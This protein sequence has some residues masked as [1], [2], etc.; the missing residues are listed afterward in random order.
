MTPTP[1]QLKRALELA[2]SMLSVH[3]L[4]DSRAVSDEFVALASVDCGIVEGRVME[5]I[6]AALARNANVSFTPEE[7]L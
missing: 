1:E 2:V 3:E 4:P 7:N 5:V 6:D